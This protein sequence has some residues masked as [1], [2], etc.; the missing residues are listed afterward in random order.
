MSG[1]EVIL[2]CQCTSLLTLIMSREDS[3]VI[4]AILPELELSEKLQLGIGGYHRRP[5]RHAYGRGT[6]P[7]RGTGGRGAKIGE[8]GSPRPVHLQTRINTVSARRS[9]TA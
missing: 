9:Q 8:G 4:E 2:R 7:Q 1:K 3:P 6:A 5:V